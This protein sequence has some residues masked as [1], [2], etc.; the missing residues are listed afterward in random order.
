MGFADL[1]FMKCSD[2]LKGFKIQRSHEQLKFP[3]V[4]ATKEELCHLCMQQ[5]LPFLDT[6]IPK[7]AVGL[8]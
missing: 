2:L 6:P 5:V 3:P 7:C 1:D 8:G 4:S